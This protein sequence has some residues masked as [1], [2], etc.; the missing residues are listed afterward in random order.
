MK[1]D[2]R[3]L[4]AP[5]V[6]VFVLVMTVQQTFDALRASGAWQPEAP[7]SARV[8]SPY[9]RLDQILARAT[10][11]SPL[12]E[13]RDPFGYGAAPTPAVTRPA[14]DRPRATP[15]PQQPVAAAQ[16]ARPTLTSIVWEPADPRATIRYDGRDFSVR[17]NSLFADFTVRSIREN[18][19][20]LDRNGQSLVLTLR[21][22]GDSR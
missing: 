19:V 21:Q 9:E 20:V 15:V 12:P 16:P 22:R 7:R 3:H 13:L 17:V 11:P 1:I 14:I 10:A 2:P 18:E 5:L 8:V 6:G 4:V